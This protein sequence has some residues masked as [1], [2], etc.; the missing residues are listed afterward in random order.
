MQKNKLLSNLTPF[1]FVALAAC[2]GTTGTC[3]V[4]D[5]AYHDTQARVTFN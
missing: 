2:Q 1:S 4:R 5:A 3:P